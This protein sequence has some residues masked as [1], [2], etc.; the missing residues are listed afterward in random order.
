M[1]RIVDNES[2]RVGKWAC[3]KA[4]GVFSLADSVAIGLERDG[5]LTAAVV[6][7]NWTGRS[8]CMHVYSEGKHWL[9][10]EFLWFVFYYP[11][12]QLKVKKIVAQVSSANEA[13]LKFDSHLGFIHEA[14]VK[15]AAKDGDMLLLTMTR[16]QCPW[17]ELR[18][19]DVNR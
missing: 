7:N 19:K 17:L 9:N 8:I 18:K 14:T 13:A 5:E 2:E 3:S 10:R 16:E 1:M 4:G 11:F 12:E 6:F 15:D